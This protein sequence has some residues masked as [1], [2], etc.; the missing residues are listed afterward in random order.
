[1]NIGEKDM[2]I[3][4][5]EQ[6]SEQWFQEKIG[7]PSASNCSKIITNGGQPS[8]QAEGY[9]FELASEIITGR[10]EEGYKSANMVVGNEREQ[11]SRMYFELIND[12]KVEQVGVVYKDDKKQFLCSPD[13]LI[14]REYGLE[15]KNVLPKTQVKYLL[16]NCLPDEYFSQI[17]MSLYITDFKYWMFTSYV[18]AM[19]PLIIRVERDEV[20]ITK[21]GIELDKFCVELEQ[22]VN[23]IR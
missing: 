1:M 10:K 15:L 19:K 11:E 4:N 5:C 13:G 7:K 14:N 18:P 22:I 9:M 17:Q 16:D 6:N 8:K 2:L 12:V 3:I 20:F 21:L 23:K